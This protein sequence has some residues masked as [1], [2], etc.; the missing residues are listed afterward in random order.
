MHHG[1]HGMH[2]VMGGLVGTCGRPLV[3][4]GAPLSFK[5]PARAF[6]GA[7]DTPSSTSPPSSLMEVVTG[8]RSRLDAMARA[9]SASISSTWAAIGGAGRIRQDSRCMAKEHAAENVDANAANAPH[10]WWKEA[11]ESGRV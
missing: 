8:T 3:E 5:S 9:S 6:G 4:A 1:Y 7:T 10:L 11:R 2:H